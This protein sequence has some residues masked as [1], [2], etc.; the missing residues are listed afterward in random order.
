MIKILKK[1]LVLLDRKQKL[2]MVGLVVILFIGAIMEAF[3]IAAIIPVVTLF[4]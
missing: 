1:L 4:L 2:Q 3:S